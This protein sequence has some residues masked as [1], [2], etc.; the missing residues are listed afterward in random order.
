M[1]KKVLKMGLLGLGMRG[2]QLLGDIVKC[3]NIRVTAICDKDSSLIEPAQK[4][5]A[6]HGF[7]DAAA[8]TDYDEMLN[9]DMDAVFVCNYATEHTPA[10]IKALEAGYHVLS[11]IPAVTSVEEARALKAT[12]LAHPELT[13]MCA[14]NCC[15]WANMESWKA[16]REA[17]KF[18]EIV[19]AEGEYLHSAEPSQITAEKYAEKNHWRMWNPAI[20]YLTHELGPLLEIMDDKVIRISCM[21]PTI[22]YNPY[23]SGSENGAALFFTKK[24]AVIRILICFGAY[25]GCTHNYR[26]IGTRGSIETNR[27]KGIDDAYSYAAL[28]EVPGSLYNKTEMPITIR[29]PGSEG[30]GHGGADQRMVYDFA[31]CVLEKKPPRL[32]VDKA[33][34]MALPG[35]LAHDSAVQ[36][37]AMIE[38]PEI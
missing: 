4:L 15:Y 28:E 36:G 9:A 11:E 27:L 21:E 38:M 1:A 31:R 33:I 22:V 20:R 3:D 17:G 6:E 5:L 30:N 14:E 35:V 8:F 19:F 7:T 2:Y 18:G 34:Q 37:G 10:A 29:Y 24:G 13:Y 23:K 32:D 12:V 25:S 26:I 16:M